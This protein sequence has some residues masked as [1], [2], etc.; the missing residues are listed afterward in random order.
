MNTK[1]ISQAKNK[2]LAGSLAAMKRAAVMAREL[3]VQTNTAIVVVRDG[4]IV[5]ITADELRKQG[6]GCA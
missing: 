1:D 2:D 3:A 4:K 5:R 6:F